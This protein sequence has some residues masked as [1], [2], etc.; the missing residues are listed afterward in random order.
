MD[1]PQMSS[2]AVGQ[3]VRRVED[4][5]FLTGRGRYTD[6][7]VLPR[8]AVLYVLRSPYAAAEIKS[9]D[10][11]AALQAPGVVS[12][13]TGA[14][15]EADGLGTLS[16][17]VKRRRRDGRPNVE[18][19]FHILA[20]ARVRHVGDPIAA[21]IA[22]DINC[23]KDAA[24]LIVVDYDPLPAV[25]STSEATQSG[26]PAVWEEA[27]DNVCFFYELGDRTAT[28]AAFS[29]ADHAS[30]LE[31]VVP[32]AYAAP[33]E[34]RGAIGAYDEGT[35]R[36]TLY[37]GVQS[38]HT[39]RGEIA[40]SVLR[41]PTDKLRLIA[42]DTGGSFGMKGGSYPEYA[43]VLWASRRTGRPVRWQAE[44]TESFQSDFHGRDNVSTVELA[45]DREGRFLALRVLTTANLGA[46]LAFNGLHSS[47]NNLG[48]LAGTYRTP[49]IYTAVTGVFTNTN[50][51]APYRGA[52]RPE[53]TYALER[54]IDVAAEEMGIDRIELRK[55]NLIPSTAMPFKT[56]L[57]FTYDCGDF[58]KNMSLALAASD[59]PR[60]SERRRSAQQRG[61]LRGIGFANAI[62]AAAGPADNPMEEAAEIRFDTAGNVLAVMGSQPQ[63]QGHE[64]T[65]AQ[66]IHD[67]LGIPMNRVRVVSGDT[68]LVY[69]GKGTFGSR[70]V[71]VGSNA[72]H[73]AAVKIIER[74]KLIAAHKLE[75]AVVDIG[76]AS[77]QFTVRGTDRSVS[78][79]DVARSAFVQGQL[80]QGLEM[81]LS[82]SA[83][84]TI[85]KATFPNGSHVCEVE[86]DPETGSTHIVGYWVVDDVGRVVNPMLVK[87]QIHGG[88]AQGIGQALGEQI[89]YDSESGQLVS[90][91][92]QDYYMPRASDVPYIETVTNEVLTSTNPLGVKGVGEA[93][94]V[95]ALP[96]VINAVVDA[97]KPYGVAHLDMPATPRRIWEAI[98][99][100]P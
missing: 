56:G 43:L 10:I 54:I 63:G 26:A 36:Y 12:I 70:S 97:L 72:L 32:R 49:Y 83:I 71:V 41:I 52:G 7:I 23:A 6:D 81:G 13:L 64:T 5:R 20:G 53:A 38:P 67:Q 98:H 3:S 27:P 93:G 16:S 69:H 46:Y 37:A 92:F 22:E 88:V 45:L 100:R 78:M 18:P 9:I 60:F 28:D 21:V 66:I 25:V 47:T 34:P 15:A 65:F 89:A 94:V 31:F 96:A 61:L 85:P 30:K 82:G 19:P 90:G 8:Q 48:G 99:A 17:R 39:V 91:S 95:G 73:H 29:K 51:I 55:R 44:R 59:W 62:E 35:G 57:V 33:I 86:I 79:E 11:E 74:G 68:D 76:Y 1:G 75:A 14:D 40:G 58:E 50:P 84:V 77:G 4:A 24:D 80:P 42:P 2:K 87:G